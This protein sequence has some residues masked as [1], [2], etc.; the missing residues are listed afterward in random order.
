MEGIKE[1]TSCDE[2]QVSNGT[3]E[4]LYCTHVNHTRI[5]NG[6]FFLKLILMFEHRTYTSVPSSFKQNPN[7]KYNLKQFWDAKH[8]PPNYLKAGHKNPF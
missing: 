2:H 1:H 4:S 3:D 7:L 8:S 6:F 5:K